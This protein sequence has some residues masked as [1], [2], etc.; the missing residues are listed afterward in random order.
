MFVDIENFKSAL[1]VENILTPYKKGSLTS[2][3]K[4]RLPKKKITPEVCLDVLKSTNYARNI[5]DMLQ[6]VAEL[7]L[8]EQGEFREAVLSIFERREQPDAVI[9]LGENIAKA[10]GYQAE[11]EEVKQ[12]QEGKFLLSSSELAYGLVSAGDFLVEEDL[13]GYDKLVCI[14]KSVSLTRLSRL[15]QLDVSQCDD[16]RLSFSNL[17]GQ[18]KL[19]FKKGSAV[20]LDYVKNLPPQIDFLPCSYVNLDG[21]DLQNW[22][23]CRFNSG[24]TVS[25]IYAKNLPTDLDVSMCNDVDLSGCDLSHQTRIRFGDKAKVRLVDAKNLPSGLDVSYCSDVNLSGC[26][27]KNLDKLEFSEGAIVTL[28]EA[29]HL[30]KRVD[31]SKCDKV[32]TWHCDVSGVQQLIF[33]NRQQRED[34]EIVIPKD[35]KGKIVYSDM[36]LSGFV[37]KMGK[38][39]D[40]DY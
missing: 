37:Q 10:N 32:K 8:H 38:L 28:S 21:V 13:K 15:P 33:K 19:C 27:L 2:D 16:V 23:N 1:A 17:V 36:L 40:K 22:V 34:S 4:T 7:P 6:C 35:W 25:L 20:Y 18:D 31:V 3:K 9:E 14:G 12:P 39:F 26:D 30:P 29:H 24:T 5:K 11:F